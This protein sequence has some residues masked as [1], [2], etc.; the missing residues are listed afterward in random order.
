MTLQLEV[1][2]IAE[3]AMIPL[4]SLTGAGHIAVQNLL[5][6]LACYTSR[7]DDK[8]LMVALQVGTVGT[9]TLVET[10]GPCVRHQLDEVLIALVVLRQDNEVIAALVLLTV[11]L[12]LRAIACYIHFAAEDGLERLLVCLGA[13]GV[14]FVHNVVKLL[15]AEHVAVVGNGHAA[16]PVADG[17]VYKILYFRLSVEYGIVR[18]YVKVNKIFHD[19]CSNARLGLNITGPCYRQTP[20][21]SWHHRSLRP[22]SWS[23]PA[24]SC[25]NRRSRR[26]G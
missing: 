22:L 15:D 5:G 9:R 11:L 2:V 23:L 12:L 20:A 26:C 25:L 6:H 13:L 1:I 24:T 17:F 10:V 7:A 8:P 21:C 4:H 3:H 19:F 18:V 14:H 16:H